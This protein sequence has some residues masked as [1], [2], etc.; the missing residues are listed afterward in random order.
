MAIQKRKISLTWSSDY[1]PGS[2]YGPRFID[3]NSLEN[4]S[5]LTK[6]SGE[7]HSKTY[8]KATIEINKEA[9]LRSYVLCA[10]GFRCNFTNIGS[11]R[12]CCNNEK[13]QRESISALF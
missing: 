9:R 6:F 4:E 5:P 3:L 7:F 8:F 1:E 2:I 12:S 13:K 10:E 11:D